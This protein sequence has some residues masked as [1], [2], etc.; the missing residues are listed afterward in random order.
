[1]ERCN[2]TAV[3][4][5]DRR[6]VAG[7]GQQTGARE[8]TDNRAATNPWMAFFTLLVGLVLLSGCAL[9][10]HAQ[11]SLAAAYRPQNVFVWKSAPLRQIRRVALL[12]M[13]CDENTP[14]M[15]EGREALEPIL[16]D[17]LT[18]TRKFELTTVSPEILRTRTG[19]GAWSCEEALP[20]DL[21]SWLG[22]SCGCDAVLFARLTVFHGYTPLAIGWRMR[23]VDVHTRATLWA[24]DEI[25]D[26][27]QPAVRAGAR[28]YQA[29]KCSPAADEWTM[30]N[31]PRQF[32]Q[33]AAARSLASL[34][35]L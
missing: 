31:C 20:S 1:M 21:F 4:G 9:H 7:A 25:L 11:V 10:R 2:S 6:T 12:P 14:G 23:L 18:K 29:Q 3:I 32:G 33:Y 19:Q 17:E 27:G 15:T 8:L 24:S 22:E 16:R 35:G 34:P 28:Q 13:A 26:A 30:A 5:R